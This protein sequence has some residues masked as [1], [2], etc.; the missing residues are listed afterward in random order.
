MSFI[1]ARTIRGASFGLGQAAKKPAFSNII[2][3]ASLTDTPSP[4]VFNPPKSIFSNNLVVGGIALA[5]GLGFYLYMTKYRKTSAKTDKPEVE[6][7]VT[8]TTSTKPSSDKK[9]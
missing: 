8:V 5:A 6:S 2:S 9:A 7:K 4:A 3:A 1:R